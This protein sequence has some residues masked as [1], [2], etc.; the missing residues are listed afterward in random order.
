M[1]KQGRCLQR[2]KERRRWK[3]TSGLKS[4]ALNVIRS[5]LFAAH[6]L[7]R[8]ELKNHY[9]DN[10]LLIDSYFC[11]VPI[12]LT[13]REHHLLYL[14]MRWIKPNSKQNKRENSEMMTRLQQLMCAKAAQHQDS[15]LTCERH[16]GSFTEPLGTE[17]IFTFS[18]IARFN[19]PIIL[20]VWR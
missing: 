8:V 7:Y 16:P 2:R 4:F 17:Y 15:F 18:W 20:R 9:Q 5:S 1:K 10:Q 12:K 19:F 13:Y 11:M 6:F 3:F 14:I